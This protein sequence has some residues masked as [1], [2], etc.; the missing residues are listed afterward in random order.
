MSLLF[1]KLQQLQELSSRR[2]PCPD[3]ASTAEE[4][5]G[6]P[7][8]DG[9]PERAAAARRAGLQRTPPRRPRLWH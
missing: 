8:N 4:L 6:E 5:R 9:R 2:T 1:N 7:A 3:D